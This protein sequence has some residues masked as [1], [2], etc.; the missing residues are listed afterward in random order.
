MIVLLLSFLKRFFKSSSM[1][2]QLEAYVIAG[3]P[4]NTY[5]VEALEKKFYQQL[6]RESHWG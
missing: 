5:D 6:N 3:N 2:A 1:S 4:Q